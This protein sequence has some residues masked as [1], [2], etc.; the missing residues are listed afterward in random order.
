MYIYIYVF[1]R[2][3][4]STILKSTCAVGDVVI[5]Y[6]DRQDTFVCNHITGNIRR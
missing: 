2:N 3:S 4:F 5:K 6:N 1:I